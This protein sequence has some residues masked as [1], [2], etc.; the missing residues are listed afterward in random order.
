MDAASQVIF[1]APSGTF[2]FVSF[3]LDN[4]ME[5]AMWAFAR[6]KRLCLGT[7]LSTAF[8]FPLFFGPLYMSG[9]DV[10]PKNG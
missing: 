1:T 8:T 6:K 5:G 2:L 4:C 9:E 10:T 7:R 3:S